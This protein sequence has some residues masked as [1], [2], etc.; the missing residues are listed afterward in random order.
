MTV[1]FIDALINHCPSWAFLIMLIMAFAI[2]VVASG[3]GIRLFFGLMQ[4]MRRSAAS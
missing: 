4:R 2:A 1:V 3:Y